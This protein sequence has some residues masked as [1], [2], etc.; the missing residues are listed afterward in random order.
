MGVEV[1][2]NMEDM[3]RLFSTT[4]FFHIYKRLIFHI[5]LAQLPDSD[6]NVDLYS[7]SREVG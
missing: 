7:G 3:V 6:R 2:H 4:S 1:K 5:L